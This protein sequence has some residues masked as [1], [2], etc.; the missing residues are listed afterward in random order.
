[1]A[2]FVEDNAGGPPADRLAAPAA[3]PGGPSIALAACRKPA[4]RPPVQWRMKGP[5]RVTLEILASADARL[6]PEQVLLSGD[7][8]AR[9]LLS[10]P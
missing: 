3:G 1:M 8:L 5:M 9:E 10:R 4:C 7:L 2:P 6:V